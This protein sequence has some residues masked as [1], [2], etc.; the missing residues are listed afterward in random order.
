MNSKRNAI[1]QH[2]TK[3]IISESVKVYE[4]IFMNIPSQLVYRDGRDK[5]NN[6]KP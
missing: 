2:K 5:T 3:Y 4:Y 6:A 1:N